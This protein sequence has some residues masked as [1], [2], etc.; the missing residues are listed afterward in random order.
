M[1]K[2]Q[3][4]EI[5]ISEAGGVT[6]LARNLGVKPPTVSQWRK[7]VRPVSA[8]LASEIAGLYPRRL[9]FRRLQ[10]VV[11]NDPLSQSAAIHASTEQAE[12]VGNV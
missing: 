4:V 6:A 5:A 11:R 3:A 8:R 2:N 12:E 7:G 1:P 9:E 10:L